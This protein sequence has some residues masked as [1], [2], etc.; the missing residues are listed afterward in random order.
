MPGRAG[1]PTS[2]RVGA[3][4][5]AGVANRNL[6]LPNLTEFSGAVKR[7]APPLMSKSSAAGS[8]TCSQF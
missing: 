7:K 2:L 8:L 5:A 1:P 3:G 6:N 4:A